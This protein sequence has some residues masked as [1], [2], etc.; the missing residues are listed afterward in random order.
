LIWLILLGAL[1]LRLALA[2]S[3]DGYWGVDGGAYLLSVNNVLGDEPTGAGFPRPPLA[4]GWLLVPFISLFGDDAGYKIW[5]ALASLCPVIPIL[6][7]ARRVGEM[8]RSWLPSLASPIWVVPFAAGFLCV[9][10]LHA[11]MLVTGALPMVAFGLLGT[12]WWAMG[13]LCERW[14]RRNAVILA[15]TIGLIPFINQTTAGIACITLPVYAVALWWFAGRGRDLG[16]RL[17]PP[18]ILG[19]IIALTALPWYLQVLPGNGMLDYPGPVIYFTRLYDIAW[20]QLTLGWG[21]GLLMVR[22][23]QEPWLRALGVLCC[24]LGTLTVFLSFDETIINVFYRSRYLLAIPFYIGF[25][26]AA[27]KYIFPYFKP[28]V[29]LPLTLA[30]FAIMGT[31]YVDQVHRQ[32]DLSAMVTSETAAVLELLRE[33]EDQ[34]AIISN[35]FT[36]ALWIAALNKVESPHTWTTTPPPTFTETDMRV[37]CVLGWRPGCDTAAAIQDLGARWILLEERF[38]YYNERA[39]GVYGSLNVEEPWEALPALPW[40]TEV[41]HQGTTMV[42]RIDPAAASQP[43]TTRTRPDG[44]SM[45]NN[46]PETTMRG[47]TAST[48]RPQICQDA[49]RAP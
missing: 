7:M 39:P 15:I 11:E 31:G 20:L 42:Y 41:Y 40:L 3:Y 12:A 19:G 14:N 43:T 10:L 4:P 16:A 38:P 35:S 44:P 22:N 46:R 9:D 32:A 45:C 1:T 29:A 5:S 8:S 25:T 2:L 26:W 37:R 48:R 6:L 34:G 33:D 13:S 27:F 49:L 18:M 17:L 30:A 36:L 21:L 28:A 47:P 24:L 23:G